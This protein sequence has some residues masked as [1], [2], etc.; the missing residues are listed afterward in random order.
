MKKILGSII[1]LGLILTTSLNA[2]AFFLTDIP[3]LS[4]QIEQNIPNQITNVS[5]SYGT[6]TTNIYFTTNAYSKVSVTIGK[7]VSQNNGIEVKKII[8]GQW[9]SSGNHTA[10][11]DEKDS[12]G[13][14]VNK[15]DS[16]YFWIDATNTTYPSNSTQYVYYT[17]L[18]FGSPNPPN[19]SGTQSGSLIKNLQV[20]P[21]K[22]DPYDNEDTNIT[23]TLS[24]DALV[25]V[26]VYDKTLDYVKGIALKENLNSGKHTYTWDGLNNNDDIVNDGTYYV[27]VTAKT[28]L[29]TETLKVAVTVKKGSTKET[30]SPRIQN[31]FVTKE[32]FDPN[33]SEVA[34]VVFTI[35]A[36]SN[37]QVYIYDGGSK[38]RELY[39]KQNVQAG[40]YI[41][42]WDGDDEK[43]AMVKEDR[44]YKYKIHV[45]NSSGYGDASGDIRVE[46][47]AETTKYPNVYND[48]IDPIVFTPKQE[49]SMKFSYKIEKSSH[50][51]VG[52]YDD[53]TLVSNIFEGNVDQGTNKVTWDGRND[54][55]NLMTDGV[56]DYK[57]T[58][59]NSTGVSKEWGKFMI[60][61]SYQYSFTKKCAGFTDVSEEDDYCPAIKWAVD[62]DVAEG[63]PNN[64]FT[65]YDTVNRVEA[66]KMILKAFNFSILE[67]DGSTLGFK[68]VDKKGWYMKYIRTA[69]KY[70]IIK[71]YTDGTFKPNNTVTKAEA[72]VMTLNA[73]KTMKGAIVSYCTS[74]PYYDVDLYT[75]YTDAAC[76]I[77]DFELTDDGQ[78]FSP[79]SLFT[80]G[81]MI[82]LLYNFYKA[83]LL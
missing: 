12:N 24:K 21:D 58:A 46:D 47:D 51:T 13:A 37:V 25:D 30:T 59:E 39:N 83:G 1:G 64:T 33:R 81:E 20:D 11:W 35:T 4:T 70:G 5:V 36:N 62:N 31:N 71:G 80:R 28:S 32:S 34:Y 42:G 68:D 43:G 27:K 22:I 29:T 78:Y 16:F 73:A 74:K 48:S 3:P 8:D 75:W 65:P 61:D 18:D 54:L 23:F 57:I 66:I 45:V 19:D 72:A 6:N 63:N 82:Q 26:K 40:T 60:L 77:H 41:I 9:L 7:K 69:K 38:V 79:N 53:G 44:T 14:S 15:S 49:G 76:Y 52:I 56:Y 67:A 17:F 2:F 50:V 10:V 55:G